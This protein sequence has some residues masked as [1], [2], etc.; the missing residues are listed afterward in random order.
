LG[1]WITDN[2]SWHWCFFINLPIGLAATF[3]VTTFLHDPPDQRRRTGQVDWLGI[4]L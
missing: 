3:L 4:S 2:A 1:G